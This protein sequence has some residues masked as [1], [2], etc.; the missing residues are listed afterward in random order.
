M[1]TFRSDMKEIWKDIPNY[2]GLYQASNLGRIKSIYYNNKILKLNNDSNDYLQVWLCKNKKKKIYKVHRLVALTFIPNPNYLPFI[3]HKDENKSN[4][5]INNLE[6]CDGI[7][8]ARYSFGKKVLQ[9][10]LDGNFIREW[11]CIKETGIDSSHIINC[12]KGKRKSA[13]GYK[14]RYK[15][16]F[17]YS[18]A[19]QT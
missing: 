15:D 17:V 18:T 8:N 10:D 11:N 4:N 7:Y 9:Y 19:K 5:N 13:G 1:M 3:N 2:E 14:W 6:W 12:C 16:G